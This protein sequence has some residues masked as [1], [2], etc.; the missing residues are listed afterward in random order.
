MQTFNLFIFTPIIDFVFP[1]FYLEWE[2]DVDVTTVKR[3][4][5]VDIGKEDE[6][7]DEVRSTCR[8]T[9]SITKIVYV[10]PNG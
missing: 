2:N 4:P 3:V 8:V 7:K 5:P 6:K 10:R 1:Y 9:N